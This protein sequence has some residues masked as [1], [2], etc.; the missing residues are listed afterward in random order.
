MHTLEKRKLNLEGFEGKEKNTDKEK[1]RAEFVKE[2]RG[3]FE[4]NMR[5]VAN[6]SIRMRLQNFFKQKNSGKKKFKVLAYRPFPSEVPVWQM[7][8]QEKNLEMYYPLQHGTRLFAK[9]YAKD[10]AVPLWQMDYIVVPGLWVNR[11]GYRLGRGG[12]FYDR[13]LRFIPRR[14][15]LFVGYD[16][17]TERDE[18]IVEVH[19]MPVGC[20]VNERHWQ[21]CYG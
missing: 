17:Q 20:V 21:N 2:H 19:D 8:D 3:Y 12:G 4:K 15:T 13:A 16:F 1:Q 9:R 6:R 10:R 11:A 14:K 18:V 5:P 7:L